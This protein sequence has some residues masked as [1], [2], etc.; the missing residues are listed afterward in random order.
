MRPDVLSPAR[1]QP[2]VRPETAVAP[3]PVSRPA[4]PA[5]AADRFESTS[6][7]AGTRTAA[8]ARTPAELPGAVQTGTPD[9]YQQRHD[10]FVRR[11]PGMTPP[12]YYLDY[13][14]KYAERF[15]KLGEGELTPKGLEWRDKTL[16]LLQEKMEALRVEDPEAFAQLE[17]D[18]AAFT[19]FAYE[20]HPSAYVEGGLYDLPVQ[21]LLAIAKTP[22]LKDIMTPLGIAQTVDALKLLRPGDIDDILIATG[23]EAAKDVVRDVVATGGA[24]VKGV[25]KVLGGVR[26]HLPWV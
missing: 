18:D 15:S 12:S 1:I 19:K 17:R 7:T 20:T 3:I 13:G 24:V 21:D 23:Q 26:D 11:N 6:A 2:T 25:G 9:Y 8:P 4:A 5:V 16:V 10:D 22:D 14:D